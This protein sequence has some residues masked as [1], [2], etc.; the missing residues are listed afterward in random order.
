M[1]IPEDGI[2][3]FISKLGFEG[4]CQRDKEGKGHPGCGNSTGKG[5]TKFSGGSGLM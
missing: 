3:L 5:L 2:E 4:I 1:S